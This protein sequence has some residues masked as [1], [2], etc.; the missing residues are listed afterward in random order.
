MNYAEREPIIL[1]PKTAVVN[2]AMLAPIAQV[3]HTRQPV[4][5]TLN[6]RLVPQKRPLVHQVNIA[7]PVRAVARHAERE[8][9]GTVAVAL[10]THAVSLY[11]DGIINGVR[12]ILV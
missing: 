4:K 3:E 6:A 5:P 12:Q 11:L 7:L 8:P 10:H 1:A 9:I 2:N